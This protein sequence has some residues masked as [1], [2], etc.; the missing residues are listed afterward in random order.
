MYTK[1]R[2][3]AHEVE[4]IIKELNHGE[5]ITILPQTYIIENNIFKY[6]TEIISLFELSSL[7]LYAI[8]FD[9]KTFLVRPNGDDFIFERL[10]TVPQFV[11]I[12]SGN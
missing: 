2:E 12:I 3:K 1:Y 8:C 4:G 11:S 7:S 9:A 6:H 5:G 10:K